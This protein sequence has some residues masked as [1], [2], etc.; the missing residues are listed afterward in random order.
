MTESTL[1]TQEQKGRQWQYRLD[2][3][4]D[5]KSYPQHLFKL[6]RNVI[7]QAVPASSH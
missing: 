6:N 4:F 2:Y 1:P 5:K 7:Q 3:K